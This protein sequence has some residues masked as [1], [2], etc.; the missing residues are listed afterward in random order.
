V[1]S[2]EDYFAGFLPQAVLA[3][4]VPALLLLVIFPLDALSGLVLLLTAPAIPIFM[5][6]IG[7][8][9]QRF[10]QQRWEKLNWMSAHFLDVLQGLVTLKT[11]GR[12]RPQILTV[13]RVS[14]QFRAA[15]LRV[16]RVAF[17]SSLVLELI[18]TLS[19]AVVAVEIG[20]R[21]LYGGISFERAFFVLLLTPE[22]Y[23][24]LRILGTRH[25]AA[26]SAKAVSGS[27][28]QILDTPASSA[29][30]AGTTV[31]LQPVPSHWRA[32]TFDH[33][34]YAYAD[35]TRP[36][37][38]DV[39]FT[40]RAGE[41]VALVGP[42]GAGKTTIANLLLRFVEPGAG[43]IL[44]D[45]VALADLPPDAWREQIA[46]VPQAPYLFNAS[47]AENIRLARPTA[48]L[49]EVIQ[50]AQQAHAHEF[51]ATLP[52]GYD[53]PLGER[54]ARLSGGQA[55]RIALARA[56]LR[57]AQLLLLDEATAHLDPAHEAL[58]QE[59]IAHLARGRTTLVIAHRPATIARADRVLVVRAG[60]LVEQGPPALLLP[61]LVAD[62]ALFAAE[63]GAA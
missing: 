60:R 9:T 63:G 40:L 61:R 34:A 56:F 55:Q 3:V 30:R 58:V 1:E 32:L 19:T 20:I 26:M 25:H 46:W 6:L 47:A 33:V 23:L 14:Q 15:T 48:S 38:C 8:L 22:F 43:R 21:L 39:S 17:L 11:F 37:L 42:S 2:L 5:V 35:G 13:E 50:A 29:S 18:A 41:C 57:A 51:I 12:S 52:Q 54:G 16:L 4:A 49:S 53:T 45:H 36:A 27:I 28:T 44:A 62:A 24:P 59:T 31:Q 7:T 10:T